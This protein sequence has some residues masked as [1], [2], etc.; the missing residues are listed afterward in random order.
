MAPQLP[1]GIDP[2]IESAVKPG[3]QMAMDTD[4]V[5]SEG[6]GI[7]AGAR[8]V[9]EYN[10][11]RSGPL[12]VMGDLPGTQRAQSVEV[13]GQGKTSGL[14]GS[15]R[16]DVRGEVTEKPG[17]RCRNSA[18]CPSSVRLP[19]GRIEPFEPERITAACSRPP[20][21]SVAPMPSC[22]SGNDRRRIVLLPRSRSARRRPINITE[23]VR[24]VVRELGQPAIAR[25]YE[26]QRPRL[27]QSYRFPVVA[28]VWLTSSRS[29]L[30]VDRAAATRSS[31]RT[32]FGPRL[33]PGPCGRP[34]RRAHSPDG[35][36]DAAGTRGPGRSC[37]VGCLFSGPQCPRPGWWIRR[38]G[39]PGIRSGGPTR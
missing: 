19:D 18:T 32:E 29:A 20:N 3:V 28:S 23:I 24:K 12:P 37:L 39:R 25:A 7:E 5:Q 13:D 14:S 6:D 27:R 1:E 22:P 30:D 33:L 34:P 26:E 36:G 35:P 16:T 10:G 31:D 9:H 11:F 17:D 4:R 8:D 38:D 21:G 2:D 15:Y